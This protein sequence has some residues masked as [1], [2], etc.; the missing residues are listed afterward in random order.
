M[1]PSWFLPSRCQ[2]LRTAQ[3]SLFLSLAFY[4]SSRS[5]SSFSDSDLENYINH[6]LIWKINSHLIQEIVAPRQSEHMLTDWAIHLHLAGK[7]SCWRS[8]TSQHGN[9]PEIPNS[10]NISYVPWRSKRFGASI[11]SRNAWRT[12]LLSSH[13]NVPVRCSQHLQTTLEGVVH[14]AVH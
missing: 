9:E 10:K 12:E 6:Y 11:L 3:G 2:T 7:V 14:W 4:S 1:L 8:H 5:S 13:R